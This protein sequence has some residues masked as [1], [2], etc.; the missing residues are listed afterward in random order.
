MSNPDKLGIYNLALNTCGEDEIY[1]LSETSKPGRLCN[2]FWEPTLRALIRDYV[3]NELK[4]Q[5]VLDADAAKPLFNFDRSYSLPSDFIRAMN[6]ED[7][8]IYEVI[9]TKLYTNYGFTPTINGIT[10][11]FVD[12][13]P[14]TITDSDSGFLRAGFKAGDTITVQGSA[15]NDGDYTIDSVVAGTI[16][17][18][19][20]DALTTEAA[21]SSVNISASED[22]IRVKFQ[23][24]MFSEDTTLFSSLFIELLYFSL[25]SKMLI[26]LTG[27]DPNLTT[28]IENKLSIL[29][30]RAFSINAL[31]NEP[32]S[33]RSS[34]IDARR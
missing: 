24:I 11:A 14:D 32:N 9:G 10:F 16:T 4:V 12:S 28:Y 30:S 13:G 5:T 15:S 6:V 8:D 23:Y 2:R 19:A 26:P 25:A 1:S 3:W 34:W 27:G 31:D 7:D 29:K 33:P 18:D 20:G 21:G 22:D 17:L